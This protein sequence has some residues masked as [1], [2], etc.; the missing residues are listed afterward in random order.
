MCCVNDE[1]AHVHGSQQR[2]MHRQSS[3]SQQQKNSRGTSLKSDGSHAFPIRGEGI[4]LDNL[5]GLLQGPQLH[6]QLG[7]QLQQGA[8]CAITHPHK[9]ICIMP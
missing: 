6:P 9:G 1:L 5:V 2:S 7:T 3:S 4:D 8:L